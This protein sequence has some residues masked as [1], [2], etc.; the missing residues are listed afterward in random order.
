MGYHFHFLGNNTSIEDLK[1]YLS[2]RTSDRTLKLESKNGELDR[3]TVWELSKVE[4]TGTLDATIRVVEALHRGLLLHVVTKSDD[5]LLHGFTKDQHSNYNA[6]YP[7]PAEWNK[8]MTQR[9]SIFQIRRDLESLEGHLGVLDACFHRNFY[10][11]LVEAV[12]EMTLFIN[13]VID[14]DGLFEG[15]EVADDAEEPLKEIKRMIKEVEDEE[16]SILTAWPNEVKQRVYGAIRWRLARIA[17]HKGLPTVYYPVFAKPTR[18]T[19]A[20]LQALPTI[21]VGQDSNLKVENDGLRVWL[22]RMGIEDGAPYPHQVTVEMYRYG[23]W[24]T[25]DQY[26]AL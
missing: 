22:S 2:V 11:P 13:C 26:Q 7:A 15:D 21:T 1:A 18:Y 6:N 5:T 19:L 4:Y 9:D 14:D 16:T 17:Y 23:Q 3:Y 10:A 24:E 25:V 12:K 8:R 20:E